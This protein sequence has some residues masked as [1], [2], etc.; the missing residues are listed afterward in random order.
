MRRWER[1]RAIAPDDRSSNPTRLLASRF[2]A[3]VQCGLT[4]EYGIAIRRAGSAVR[5]TIRLIALF[6]MTACRAQTRTARSTTA[7]GTPHRRA[8]SARRAHGLPPRRRTPAPQHRA[9]LPRQ[10]LVALRPSHSH[11]ERLRAHRDLTAPGMG[12]VGSRRQMTSRF[13]TGT[14]NPLPHNTFRDR[15]P[16]GNASMLASSHPLRDRRTNRSHQR[17]PP[18]ICDGTVVSFT[19]DSARRRPAPTVLTGDHVHHDTPR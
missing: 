1:R 4:S 6:R 17:G 8:R 9:T 10:V 18:T 12:A 3:I 2:T 7:A 11:V 16:C 15:P 13:S 5:T 19:A 14:I